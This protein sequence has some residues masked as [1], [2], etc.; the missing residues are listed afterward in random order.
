MFNIFYNCLHDCI[1]YVSK[2]FLLYWVCYHIGHKVTKHTHVCVFMFLNTVFSLTLLFTLLTCVANTISHHIS[3]ISSYISPE[4]QHIT[5][6][7]AQLTPLSA[8]INPIYSLIMAISS[9]N[10][11]MSPQSHSMSLHIIP[12]H[13]ISPISPQC[14]PISPQYNSSSTQY[15][16]QI[17][18][19]HPNIFPCHH[20]SPSHYTCL[21]HSCQLWVAGPTNFIA[22]NRSLVE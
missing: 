7:S 4:S 15:H 14:Q 3:P 9:S 2:T 5:P 13:K 17:T 19:Y 21:Q 18:P 11:P 16:P 6:I 22:L 8:H 12:H 20:I 1:H 10:H